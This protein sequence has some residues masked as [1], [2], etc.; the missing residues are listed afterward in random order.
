MDTETYQIILGIIRNAGYEQMDSNG[1]GL[2]DFD[3]AVRIAQERSYPALSAQFPEYDTSV[4]NQ[5]KE[6]FEREFRNPPAE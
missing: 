4:Y 2:T 5:M 6:E 1:E 3:D